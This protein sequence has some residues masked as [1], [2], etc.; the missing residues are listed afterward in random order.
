MSTTLKST[1]SIIVAILAGITCGYTLSNWQTK[2][3]IDRMQGPPHQRFEGLCEHMGR[4]LKLSEEQKVKMRKILEDRH[5]QMKKLQAEMKPK[6]QEIFKATRN[7]IRKILTPEQQELFDKMH[8]H[9]KGPGEGMHRPFGHR[10]R[11]FGKFGPLGEKGKRKHSGHWGDS[12][13]SS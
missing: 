3:L 10:G 6:M 11:G 9:W 4:K 7:T 8:K 13:E 12:A 1:I 5:E 2:S